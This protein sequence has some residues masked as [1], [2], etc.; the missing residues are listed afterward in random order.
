M[1]LPPTFSP[2]TIKSSASKNSFIWFGPWPRLNISDPEMIKE[3]LRKPDVFRKP[4]P[5]IAK[6]LIG[7]GLLLLEGEKWS[8]H[9]KIVNPAFHADKLKNMVPAIGLS[10]SNM[11]NKLKEMVSGRR[12]EGG[13]EVDMWPYIDELTGDMISRTAFGSSH[14]QGSKIFQLQKERVKLTLQLLQ[15]SFIPG[16]RHVPTKVNRKVK[17]LNNEIQSILRSIIEKRHNDAMESGEGIFGD[18]LLGTL[19]ESNARL[20]GEDRRQGSK[21]GGMS[22]DDVIDECKLF[23]IAGSET[24]ACL[25]VWTMV[26]LCK[27]PEW[28]AQA[29]EEVI[30]VF[31]NS[32]PSLEGLSHLKIVTMILQE[33]LRLYPPAPLVIRGPKETVKLG[34]LTIPEGVHM[35]LLIGLL[36]CD[37]EIW[38]DDAKD[39]NPLRFSEGISKAAVKNQSSFVPFTAG[40]RVC[41]AQN[42]AMIEAK[43]AIAMILRS[44]LFELS[45]SYLHAPFAILTLQPQ[46]GAPMILHSLEIK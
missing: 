31:G 44:F 15:F 22:I 8:K 13:F 34:N 42:F 5:E 25:L 2:I 26:L 36:H 40:P 18:D 3:I 23:Y 4:L 7:G 21:N 6:T 11:I 37:P 19:M 39:F 1:I 35:T 38:G 17:A 41:I 10:C 12:N 20:V 29:R 46:H 14:E 24:T 32:E 43:M 16:W 27:H 33:A 28:Q 30:R 45:P 9:R